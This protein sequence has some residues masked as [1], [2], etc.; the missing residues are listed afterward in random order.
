MVTSRKTTKVRPGFILNQN[1]EA[2]WKIPLRL[3]G[4]SRCGVSTENNGDFV[5]ATGGCGRWRKIL[6][7]WKWF[8]K[9][10]GEEMAFFQSY[11]DYKAQNAQ[12]TTALGN[13]NVAH[14]PDVF[15]KIPMVRS[16]ASVM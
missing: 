9:K 10:E 5:V 8:C 15:S 6:E 12:V 16:W 11:L 4:S 13:G 3:K 1:R 2:S 7:L 14:T